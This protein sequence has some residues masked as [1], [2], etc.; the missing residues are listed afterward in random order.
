M[1][2]SVSFPSFEWDV[3]LIGVLYQMNSIAGAD[4]VPLGYWMFSSSQSSA[5]LPRMRSRTSHRDRRQNDVPGLY[6]IHPEM[7]LRHASTLRK[8]QKTARVLHS[9]LLT[10]RSRCESDSLLWLCRL[11]RHAPSPRLRSRSACTT[12][13]TAPCCTQTCQLRDLGGGDGLA[14][15]SCTR[16]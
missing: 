16:W 11:R 15:R 14:L 12:R 5:R 3:F 1:S 4:H 8:D 13:S 9:R 7:A 10:R 2:S 6:H